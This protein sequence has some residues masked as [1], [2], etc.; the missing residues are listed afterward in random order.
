MD[1]GVHCCHRKQLK[2]NKNTHNNNNNLALTY[3]NGVGTNHLDIMLDTKFHNEKE[4]HCFV[5]LEEY[6]RNHIDLQM[7][8]IFS[9]CV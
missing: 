4:K 6:F 7:C 5:V 3:L 2:Q 8:N 1:K 9:I